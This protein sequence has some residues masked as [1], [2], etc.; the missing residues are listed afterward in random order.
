MKQCN[1][2]KYLLVEDIAQIHR[3]CGGK[4]DIKIKIP[5]DGHRESQQTKKATY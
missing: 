4:Q 2:V 1:E 5:K 3:K